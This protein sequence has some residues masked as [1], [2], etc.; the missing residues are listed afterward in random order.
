MDQN[1]EVDLR[2]L[3]I[4]WALHFRSAI[5][6]CLCAFAIVGAYKGYITEQTELKMEEIYEKNGKSFAQ[7]DNKV[8]TYQI[9]VTDDPNFDV[10]AA[11]EIYITITG[12][13]ATNEQTIANAL[14]ESIKGDEKK[15]VVYEIRIVTD[16]S[17]EVAIESPFHAFVKNGMIGAAGILFLHLL[18][19]AMKYISS[20]V[21][22]TVSQQEVLQVSV[23][24]QKR[25]ATVKL[26]KYR[27]WLSKALRKIGDFPLEEINIDNIADM[28]AA[29]L[30][31]ETAKEK[32]QDNENSCRKILIAGEALMSDKRMIVEAL[33]QRLEG[34]T[35]IIAESLKKNSQDREKLL[36]CDGVLFA[37]VYGKTVKTTALEEKQLVR[38]A[39]KMVLGSIWI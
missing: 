7:P 31:L 27:D 35:F 26:Y 11:R 19:F 13:D 1:K 14:I 32:R 36:N 23:L 8:N 22:M 20:S 4:Y 10:K 34:V 12:K 29:N 2:D 15:N 16:A 24:A 9:V 3:L 30:K 25:G 38:F 39:K 18:F 28:A 37:E 6:L 5:V 33:S 21:I 17:V